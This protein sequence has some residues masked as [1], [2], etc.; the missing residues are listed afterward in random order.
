M[1]ASDF[2][3]I[4]LADLPADIV[5]IIIPEAEA[6]HSQIRELKYVSFFMI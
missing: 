3:E 4:S 6:H 2:T 5:R 1:T